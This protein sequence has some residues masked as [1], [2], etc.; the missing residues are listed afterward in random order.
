[1]EE[2]R[3]KTLEDIQAFFNSIYSTEV[4][5]MV[6]GTLDIGKESN[7]VAATYKNNQNVVI[8]S[9]FMDFE[10]AAALAVASAD[11]PKDLKNFIK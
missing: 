6:E 5:L 4:S 2:F 10:I 11:L 1:M 3:S 8:G 9:F 7:F